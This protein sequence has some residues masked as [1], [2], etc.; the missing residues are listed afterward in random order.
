M[1]RRSDAVDAFLHNPSR[2]RCGRPLRST[3]DRPQLY[4]LPT[5]R[6][7]LQKVLVALPPD[8]FQ[9]L[10]DDRDLQI[11]VSPSAQAGRP[12]PDQI[13]P[14]IHG[15]YAV[16]EPDFMSGSPRPEGWTIKLG[17]VAIEAAA[18]S[19]LAFAGIVIHECC[20][21]LLDH[22][23]TDAADRQRLE[24]GVCQEG[25][26]RGFYQETAAFVAFY[27]ERFPGH[28]GIICCLPEQDH[29]R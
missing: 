5:V 26:Q 19:S 6:R 2:L 28:R 7:R 10:R 3:A 8:V 18:D 12:R 23:P 11:W 22:P 16:R 21:V 24:D 20:H 1:G 13:D 9:V 14:A 29:R 27:K 17:Q 4:R 25:C 15:S